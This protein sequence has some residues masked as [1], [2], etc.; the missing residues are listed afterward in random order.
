[1]T[2]I[3]KGVVFVNYPTHYSG[4]GWGLWIKEP[5]PAGKGAF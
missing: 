4:N 2:G 1:M 3:Q 5:D